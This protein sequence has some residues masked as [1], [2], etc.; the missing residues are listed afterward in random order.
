M[1]TAVLRNGSSCILEIKLAG[2]AT[3]F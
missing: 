1:K 3:D 2:A